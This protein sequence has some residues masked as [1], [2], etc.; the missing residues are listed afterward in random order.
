MYD[1]CMYIY[2]RVIGIMENGNYHSILELYGCSEQVSQDAE[3]NTIDSY[4]QEQAGS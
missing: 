1:V 4:L 2:I 3:A